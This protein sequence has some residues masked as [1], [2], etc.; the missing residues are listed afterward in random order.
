MPPPTQAL[1]SGLT[2][3]V[4]LLTGAVSVVAH[5]TVLAALLPADPEIRI[6]GGAASTPAALGSAFEDF[7]QGAI[8]SRP[9]SAATT[10]AEPA[11]DTPRP[12]PALASATEATPRSET[13]ETAPESVAPSGL[14]AAGAAPNTPLAALDAPRL[15]TPPFTSAEPVETTPPETAAPSGFAPAQSVEPDTVTAEARPDIAVREADSSTTHPPQRPDFDALERQREEQREEQQRAEAERAQAAAAAQAAGDS[16]RNARR[17]ASDGSTGAAAQSAPS[18]APQAS[19]PGN[20]AASNYPGQVMRRIQRVRQVR[21][22]ARGSAV[23]AF[24]I[25]AHGGLASASLARRSGSAE[26]DQAALD[27]IRRAA[28]FPTPPPGAQR[29]FSFEFVGR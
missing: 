5:G 11:P 24:T 16:D 18:P 6:E 26:L 27:H 12:A 2:W 23:V 22:R 17:G 8:P 21:L 19:A 25:A 14:V 10:E 4:A 1:P 28:P 13:R 3:R 9:S 20:A 7:T 29:S 15:L